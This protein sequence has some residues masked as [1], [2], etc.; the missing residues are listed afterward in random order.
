MLWI[1]YKWIHAAEIQTRLQPKIFLVK[2]GQTGCQYFDLRITNKI[3]TMH[4][5]LQSNLQKSRLKAS[6]HSVVHCNGQNMRP[7]AVNAQLHPHMPNQRQPRYSMPHGRIHLVMAC[8]KMHSTNCPPKK[9]FSIFHFWKNQSPASL[10]ISVRQVDCKR[11]LKM[12]ENLLFHTCREQL[13]GCSVARFPGQNGSMWA[14]V[15]LSLTK[16]SLSQW[17]YQSQF[18]WDLVSW[19]W[20]RT[21]IW[22]LIASI[23]L[24]PDGR[25]VLI[26]VDYGYH[27]NIL[28][29]GLL[30]WSLV[31]DEHGKWVGYLA[32]KAFMGK[33]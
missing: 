16:V 23:Q 5:L 19:W 12:A 32:L 2:H 33:H 10:L 15:G 24:M 21:H 27:Q 13:Q 28:Q 6:F 7:K 4:A 1:I 17:L 31:S 26:V 30:I 11:I 18:I 8:Q 3:S 25:G 20:N 9:N 29:E 22:A 14:S